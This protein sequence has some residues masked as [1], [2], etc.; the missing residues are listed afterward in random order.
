MSVQ[1]KVLS[2]LQKV[3]K[4]NLYEQCHSGFDI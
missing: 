4:E 1:T 2:D 3:E